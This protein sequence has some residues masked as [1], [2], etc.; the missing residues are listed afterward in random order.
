MQAVIH[1]MS[2]SAYLP[3]LDLFGI[4][5]TQDMIERDIVSEHRPISTLDSDSFIQFEIPTASDEYFKFEDLFLHMK[6]KV[7][8]LKTI[9]TDEDWENIAPVNYLLHSMIKQL[10]IFIGDKQ[11][12]TSPSTYSYKAYFETLLGFN[13]EAKHSHLSSALWFDDE[14]LKQ[15]NPIKVWGAYLKK[16]KE[17]DLLGRLHTD[18][19]YQGRCLLG[20]AKVIVKILLNDPKFFFMAT[21]GHAP[22]MEFLEASLIVHRSK[23][24]PQIV[25]GHNAALQMAPARYPITHSIVKPCTI[26]KGTFDVHIDNVHSGQLPRRIFVA[27]VKNQAYCGDYQLNPYNFKHFGITSFSVFLDGIQYPAKAF[28]PDFNNDLF[29]R[30]NTHFSMRLTCWELSLQLI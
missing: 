15:D 7:K 2:K 28:T 13:K 10:D 19:A 6:V 25:E 21:K 17:I 9:K 27:F 26:Q 3:E 16:N 11:V 14:N 5:P 8:P 24:Y 20:G 4:P 12:T 1:E 23:V 22:V 29:Q 30:N 18:L